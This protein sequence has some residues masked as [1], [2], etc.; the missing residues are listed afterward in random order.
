MAATAAG[1]TTD[2]FADC[3]IFDVDGVLI[4][5]DASFPEAIRL[6]VE[7]EWASAGRVAD[8]RGYSPGHNAVLKRHGAFNDDYD[9]AWLLLNIAAGR[10]DRLSQA[11]PAPAELESIVASCGEDGVAWCRSTFAETFPRQAV[12]A[13]GAA[14]YFGEGNRTGTYRLETP[15]LNCRWDR[16]PLPAYIYT[17]RDLRE[18]RL[19]Q[20]LLGWRDFPD[21]R[22]VHADMGM[23]KP[24]PE[25]LRHLC[26]RFG[27]TAPL[28]FGDTQSDRLAQAHFGK[29]RFVAI[30]RVLAEEDP[31]DRDL[32]FD[33]VQCA[34]ARLTEWRR[35][36]CE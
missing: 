23:H 6:T 11:L 12:R 32:R 1:D 5:A 28:F 36:T 29:G 21:E 14:N 22:V 10:G 7:Q 19:A 2:F 8:A 15:L 16:L 35:E 20:E 27:H 9:I 26:G 18:W 25:G 34:L 13:A 31:R 30:G 4:D 33:D 3:L 17:G 24:S